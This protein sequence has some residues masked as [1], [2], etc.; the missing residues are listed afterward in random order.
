MEPLQQQQQQQQQQQKQPHLAPLQMD[1]REKQGQQMREAQFLYAQKLVTQPTLLSATAGRPSGSTPLGPLA[2][3]P[4]TAA[5]AQVF[6]RGNM[7]SEPE[8][9]D[10]GL[11]DEDGDD[12]VA[13]VAEKETQAASKY[14]HVQ[15]VARQDPRVAPMSNLLPAPGLPPHGQQA[16]EDHTKD[17]SKASPSVSTAGQPNWNL[18]EQLKQNGGLAWSDDADGG[19]GREISRDFAKLYELDGDPERKEFLDDLFVF[20]QKRGTP[21]NRI[22]IM[23]KQIL[24]LYML[25]KLV[26][27]KGGLVEII[28]KKIWR[29]I[30]K[31]LNLPTS[32]T[33]A[34]FTLR[35]QYMKYLYAYECEKK[36]LSSPAEL[37]AAIDGNRREGRRPSYSSSLFGYS[38]AAATA[39]AAAG[40]PALL[41]PP[42]IRFPILGLGSSSGTNTSSPRISPATTLRKGDGAPV[43]TVPVPNRLAVP[44]TLASQQAGTRTAALEQLRERLESGEPAE[45][46]A[47][48]LSEEEQRLVQQAF[49]RNF[50]SM[51]R[52]LPM[53]I[54][55]N[56]RA[57][58]RAE[59]SAAALN[60]TTS[61]IGSINMSVD[62][63]GTTYAGV[64][65]AQ[66]PVVHLIT[67]SAPQ[68]LG[69]SASSSSS[70]HCSPSPTSSRGTPSAEPSTSWSL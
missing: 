28:N 10:G 50:F 70:S 68:S 38:P 48:R 27:E 51:A 49:Q 36:A 54:R 34:A 21:I 18:D 59:A 2:R 15:K 62:I 69:S 22:P 65:F 56:G 17:A 12:E 7:N 40:A 46:K 41:S 25:Y 14:F 60:L 42:K 63:D 4:P 19:R 43:T 67:G 44:V 64:L 11:E 23:A 37:Q 61:S 31:G 33:S 66:K 1:A 47:S 26:T 57:E 58:D 45:K 29:E 9:E 3:V 6:E 52:Q 5:V 39:A 8:E 55:I 20:M 16:K 24:D 35:T 53:K 30:T 32:I 13:E